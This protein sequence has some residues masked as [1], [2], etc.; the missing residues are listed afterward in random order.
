MADTVTHSFSELYNIECPSLLPF[1]ESPDR[2]E[3]A[4]EVSTFL[5]LPTK[6]NAHPITIKPAASKADTLASSFIGLIIQMQKKGKDLSGQQGAQSTIGSSPGSPIGNTVE[7]AKPHRPMQATPEYAFLD[8][9]QELMPHI[10]AAVPCPAL[11]PS[12]LSTAPL[13]SSAKEKTSKEDAIQLEDYLP[14]K[15]GFDLHTLLKDPEF[16]ELIPTESQWYLLSQLR[17]HAGM[18]ER[19]FSGIKKLAHYYSQ[20]FHME[21]KFP[22]ENGKVDIEFNWFEAF[23]PDKQVLCNCIQYEK[24]SVLFNVAAIYS[25]LGSRTRLWTMD[26]KRVAAGHFQKAAGILIFIRDSL[27]QRFKIKLDKFADMNE[28]TLSTAATFMLA[29]AAECFYDKTH[30]EKSSSPVIA[31]VAVYTSDLY[32]VAHRHGKDGCGILKHRFPRLWM[33][34]M[35][36]KSTLF[37]AI[38]HFHTGPVTSVD[39]VVAE[40]LARLA[41]AKDLITDSYRISID[42][43][44]ILQDIVKGYLC[45]INNACLTVDAANNVHIHDTPFDSR[46]LSPLKRPP[47]ALVNP[48]PLENCIPDLYKFQDIFHS[49]IA[50]NQREDVRM[51]NQESCRVA[52]TGQNNLHQ[53]VNDIDEKSIKFGLSHPH[54]IELTI[55]NHGVGVLRFSELKENAGK[56]IKKMQELQSEESSLSSDEMIQHLDRLRNYVGCSIQEAS[57]HLKEFDIS[58]YSSDSD[59]LVVLA[60]LQ[61]EVMQQDLDLKQSGA[62]YS[63]LKKT[64]ETEVCQ[65]HISSWTESKLA[66]IIPVL[67]GSK[68]DREYASSSI[69]RQYETAKSRRQTNI[70]HLEELR[71]ACQIKMIELRT[72]PS[73]SWVRHST[74]GIHDAMSSQRLRLADICTSVEKMILEKDLLLQNIAEQISILNGLSVHINDEIEQDKLVTNFIES[75]EKSM[76]FRTDTQNEIYMFIVLREETAKTLASVIKFV[77]NTGNYGAGNGGG[78]SS[79]RQA[80]PPHPEGVQRDPMVFQKWNEYE[81]MRAK[82]AGK[83]HYKTVIVNRTDS[84][85][86]DPVRIQIY[87]NNKPEKPNSL[88]TRKRLALADLLD[89]NNPHPLPNTSHSLEIWQRLHDRASKQS[90]QA[91]TALDAL[92]HLKPSEPVVPT[93]SPPNPHE[94][95][96]SLAVLLAAATAPRHPSS[97]VRDGHQLYRRRSSNRRISLTS[98]IPGGF[99]R[100][101]TPDVAKPIQSVEESTHISGG[102][103]DT[104]KGSLSRMFTFKKDPASQ[105]QCVPST[106]Q[107]VPSA[108]VRTSLNSTSSSELNGRK[109]SLTTSIEMHTRLGALDRRGPAQVRNPLS[110]RVSTTLPQSAQV[111]S[112]SDCNSVVEWTD[113]EDLSNQEDTT[114]N[115]EQ[116][117]GNKAGGIDKVVDDAQNTL[118]QVTSDYMISRLMKENA[119]LRNQFLDIRKGSAAATGSSRKE[120]PTVTK[121][122]DALAA[123]IQKM[124]ELYKLQEGRIETLEKK[125]VNKN[126]GSGNTKKSDHTRKSEKTTAK[127]EKYHREML[128]RWI[129]DQTRLSEECITT[130]SPCSMSTSPSDDTPNQQNTKNGGPNGRKGDQRNTRRE[131]SQRVTFDGNKGEDSHRGKQQG[132]KSQRQLGAFSQGGGTH[133]GIS[134]QNVPPM[135]MLVPE[136][137]ITVS[138][139]RMALQSTNSLLGEGYLCKPSGSKLSRVSAVFPNKSRT[140]HSGMPQAVL[141]AESS[142]KKDHTTLFEREDSGMVGTPVRGTSFD[143][144]VVNT[145]LKGSADPTIE[146]GATHNRVSGR[147]EA[148]Y[149]KARA[150]SRVAH[151]KLDNDRLVHALT[152]LDS[153]R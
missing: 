136:I 114:A 46:L 80:L 75:V 68:E 86:V 122:E 142:R 127:S 150:F 10:L 47:Q 144:A 23:S 74:L 17:I 138:S 121:L 77:T 1:N 16:A 30:D 44:G 60:E 140:P 130:D 112:E 36:C 12:I 40:R 62:K 29:Q 137:D 124:M 95:Q 9:Q 25:Q 43:G 141:A 94:A 21:E 22:F 100:D 89:L 37:G 48:T 13:C 20:L 110:R 41:A 97:F 6:R 72:V 33:S 113:M 92:D 18:P 51:I 4:G 2:T 8:F 65:F 149:S 42:V 98:H 38:A 83:P 32:D 73:E 153:S 146:H 34:N 19:S 145:V 52:H 131:W 35:K 81:G 26:G 70:S 84:H 58:M 3:G 128:A 64:F 82:P 125:A 123:N 109:S 67:N 45:T 108:C 88:E 54:S 116:N 91:Q 59:R 61:S 31:L 106:P 111:E 14:E 24:A 129:R 71:R 139:K 7:D 120:E 53:I 99:P 107:T 118:D 134:H 152:S 126:G 49:I 117:T 148:A 143:E 87:N 147:N 132:S 104:V 102:L 66:S 105:A 50:P 103:L 5:G 57:W 39:R 56:F 27:S 135:V 101:K 11:S 55:Q 78:A 119:R 93:V 133:F 15:N 69:R 85:E 151:M 76:L 115:I 79:V 63:E 96:R 90:H 28:T